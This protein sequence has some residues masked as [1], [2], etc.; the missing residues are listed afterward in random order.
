[1]GKHYAVI[2]IAVLVAV[3]LL[4]NSVSAQEGA[5]P[6]DDPTSGFN[7]TTTS[8][9][10]PAAGPAANSPTEKIEAVINTS[11]GSKDNGQVV[12]TTGNS[13][14]QG[15]VNDFL[16]NTADKIKNAGG[17]SGWV[18]TWEKKWKIGADGK[19]VDVLEDWQKG[20]V[21]GENLTSPSPTVPT[22]P[23]VPSTS[24]AKTPEP[25]SPD[26]PAIAGPSIPAGPAT[27]N[28]ATPGDPNAVAKAD[29]NA[30]P[31]QIFGTPSTDPND[32][33][34][35]TPP[36]TSVNIAPPLLGPADVR[37]SIQ[38]PISNDE[39]TFGAN[40]YPT[41]AAAPYQPVQARLQ[42]AV[43]EDTRVRIGLELSNAIDPDD[44]TL[45]I[46]DNEGQHPPVPTAAYP[47]FRHMFRIPDDQRYCARVLYKH[48]LSTDPDA[49][50]IIRVTIPVYRLGF[51]HHT[52]DAHQDRAKTSK[53]P[54]QPGHFQSG[55]TNT[56]MYQNGAN[57]DLSDLYAPPGQ[58]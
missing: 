40:V 27:S 23:K 43:P 37:L 29:P 31:T 26:G 9:T 36:P 58:N 8:T 25:A 38:N 41:Q 2:G 14:Q 51:E 32:A 39:E 20:N 53:F 13:T 7:P 47:N 16:N 30:P 19:P 21:N 50:E 18:W 33:T 11:G 28:P 15:F 12:G 24:T 49:K 54:G 44:V 17:G 3:V 4:G 35:P 6:W 10:D 55:D 52:I 42:K 1:M 45:V 57:V 5:L 34:T 56:S 46:I 48:P 22:F